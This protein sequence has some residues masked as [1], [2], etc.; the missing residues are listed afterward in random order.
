MTAIEE[1][2]KAV[3][4]ALF[5][6]YQVSPA[7]QFVGIRAGDEQVRMRVVSFGDGP[8]VVL[9]HAASWFAAH[10][11]P[12]CALIP[13]RR[14]YCVDMPGH[15]LSDG[16]N[17]RQRDLRAFQVDLFRQ[18]IGN[19]GLTGVP[20]VGNS[21]GGMTALWLALDAPELVSHLGVVGLPATAL[22]GAKPDLILSALSIPGLNRL[23][24]SLPSTH[25][26]SRMA[27]RNAL[28]A[29]AMKRIA[30]ETMSEHVLIRRRPEFALTIST[31]MPETHVWRAGRPAVVILDDELAK[32]KQPTLFLWGERDPFGS[33]EIGRRAAGLMPNARLETVPGAH[34]PQLTDTVACANSLRRFFG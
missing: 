33:P 14:F 17:Y 23:M 27:L 18:L 19:L 25:F 2:V 11:A 34:H 8:A 32:L 28:G 31:W 12:L 5:R 10:W 16:I 7:E 26:S 24:L 15:G 21:L 20:V 30:P 6:R 29:D 1:Q 9:L 22:P 4:A 13:G 3:E